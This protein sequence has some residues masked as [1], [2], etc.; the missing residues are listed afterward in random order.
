MV[1]EIK[2]INFIAI[3]KLLKIFKHEKHHAFTHCIFLVVIGSCTNPEMLYL[4]DV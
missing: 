3:N 1:N 2:N 4:C